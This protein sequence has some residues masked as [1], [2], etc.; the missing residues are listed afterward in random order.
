MAYTEQDYQELKARL[1]TES[2]G[3]GDVPN[4]EN[5][6][7]ITS[8]PAYQSVEGQDVPEIVR[9]P[10]TL[11]AAPALDSAIK[12]NE[13]AANANEKSSAANEAAQ[14]ANSA[15]D[16]VDE[17]IRNAEIVTDTANVATASA[18]QAAIEANRSADTAD[19]KAQAAQEAADNANDTA[20][21]PTY[22]GTDHYVYKWNKT[23]KAYDKTGIYAKGNPGTP[24]C[25]VGQ[26]TTLE[27]LQAAV[28]NGASINGFMAIGA[29]IPYDYYAWVNGDWANQGQIV[30]GSG[31][32]VDIPAVVVDLTEQS[33][34]TEIFEAFDGK[35]Y[36]MEIC[37]KIYNNN[38]LS[39]A[40][41]TGLLNNQTQKK[42]I[43][44]LSSS[45]VYTDKNNAI[46]ELVA[47]LGENI[48]CFFISVKNG[49]ATL[50]LT[51]TSLVA[52]APSSGNTYG[53]KNGDW[54]EVPESSDVLTKTNTTAY[55][56]TGDYHPSTKKYTEESAIAAVDNGRK[57]GYT[58]SLTTID[59]TGL[60]EH[61]WYPVVMPLGNEHTVR[62][63]VTVGLNSES[64]PSWSTH[65]QGFSVRKIWEVNGTDW[66]ASPLNRNILVSDYCFTDIDP[67]RGI[68]QLTN[69][70]DEYVYVRGG[71]RYFFYTSHNV[72]PV[73]HTDIYSNGQQSV[74]PT[75]EAPAVIYRTTPVV[76]IPAEVYGANDSVSSD[77]LL[78]AWQGVDNFRRAAKQAADKNS[79]VIL[80]NSNDSLPSNTAV[81][82]R[83]K[84]TDDNNFVINVAIIKVKDNRYLYIEYGIYLTKGIAKLMRSTTNLVGGSSVSRIIEISKAEYD[85][86]SSKDHNTLYIIPT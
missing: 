79:I 33:T 48:Y 55:T 57:A 50:K 8:L 38:I 28:P 69:F 84:Y 3:V 62:I 40:T 10:L 46:L 73:L 78:A 18:N 80:K 41:G 26:Y 37:Q 12:A 81:S 6:D 35:E 66:G 20:E 82:N 47:N 2:Q 74:S 75:A 4:A 7:G 58:M 83:S 23:T 52:E 22:I 54:T 63:E 19:A 64:V 42:Q 16:R 51:I 39:I 59:A 32:I 53:R 86:L 17:V 13:A 11:L 36:F 43:T 21:H 76:I 44:F 85:A 61:T 70:S 60:D 71:G 68:G 56:P 30:G 49:I 29:K 65:A 34:S 1:Q 15:A 77:E 67:V 24:F 9:A 27:A 14:V 31:N 5:L 72:I 45:A 25:V